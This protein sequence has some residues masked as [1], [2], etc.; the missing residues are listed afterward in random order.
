MFLP[1]D[2][3][4]YCVLD[5]KTGVDFHEIVVVLVVQQELDC[6][7]VLVANMTDKTDSIS[8]HFGA[9]SFIKSWGWSD[10]HHF[11]MSSLN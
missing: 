6:S 11:L 5:L 7:N 10:F 9:N 1:S 3:F 8:H 2:F 4:S